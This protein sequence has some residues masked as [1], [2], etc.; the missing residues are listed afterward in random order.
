MSTRRS[1]FYILII[2]VTVLAAGCTSSPEELEQLSY[3]PIT[4]SIIM[5]ESVVLKTGIALEIRLLDVTVAG[6]E[7]IQLSKQIIKNP[8]KSRINFLLR[9]DQADIQPFGRYVVR[10][11][12]Y[13]GETA[14]YQSAGDTDVLTR[15]NPDTISETLVP[16]F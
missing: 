8:N 2:L 6:D 7:E 1:Y 9:F 12:V 13:E 15:G 5:D 4:G 3:K 10:I 14:I 16:V 11:A